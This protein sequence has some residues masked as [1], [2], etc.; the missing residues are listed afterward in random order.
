M[1]ILSDDREISS[2]SRLIGR[3]VG[4]LGLSRSVKVIGEVSSESEIDKFVAQAV[5]EGHLEAEARAFAERW[6]AAGFR[7]FKDDNLGF[8]PEDGQRGDIPL[9][10]EGTNTVRAAKIIGN[11]RRGQPLEGQ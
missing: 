9:R 11:A 5:R 7:V 4:R 2:L 10:G 3:A 1:E 8:R 6:T